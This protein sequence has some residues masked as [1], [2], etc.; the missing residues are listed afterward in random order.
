MAASA[1]G[2]AARGDAPGHEEIALRRRVGRVEARGT[3]AEIGH[4]LARGQRG[5]DHLRVA[6]IRSH[7]ERVGR[8]MEVGLD[9][10]ERL[11]LMRPRHDGDEDRRGVAQQQPRELAA[12]V[13]RR[14]DDR[15]LHR[16][17]GKIM[18][19]SG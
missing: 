1:A 16:H 17:G 19:L 13:A 7:Q 6:D 4:G 5:E 3:V 8:S 12:R 15:D 11:P 18:R 14:A 2:I 9:R 10:A